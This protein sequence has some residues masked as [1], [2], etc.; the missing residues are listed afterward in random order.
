MPAPL[1]FRSRTLRGTVILY[2]VCLP[3]DNRLDLFERGAFDSS[4]KDPSG[5]EALVDHDPRKQLATFGAGFRL[6]SDR[7][8]LRAEIDSPA[9]GWATTFF[10]VLRRRR[11]DLMD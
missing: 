7:Q 4:L 9:I 11:L 1:E 2:N 5:I 10:A 6:E 3:A 8:G